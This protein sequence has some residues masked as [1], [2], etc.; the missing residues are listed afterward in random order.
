[1]KRRLVALTGALITAG[2]S[3]C[4]LL[5]PKKAKVQYLEDRGTLRIDEAHSVSYLRGGEHGSPRVIFVHGTPGEAKD[6]EAYVAEPVAGS[7]SVAIDRFGFGESIPKEA[8]TSLHEQALAIEPFLVKQGGRW[9][10]LVGHSYGGPVIA[11]AAA[12][13]PDRIGGIVIV[14]GALD[15]GLEKVSFMQ[16][17][18]EFSFMP[19]L[20]P[21]ALR[22]ANRE[23]IPLKG[24]LEE[25]A[26]L[27]PTIKVPIIIIH[28][29]KDPL[30][31]FSNVAYMQ[32][33]FAPEVVRDTIVLEGQNHFLPWNSEAVIRG[34]IGNLLQ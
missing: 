30:V 21:G 2:L 23:L 34:A 20:L 14:A 16:R 24:E 5:P 18:G 19:G 33:H 1:M 15:P 8:V 4:S 29:T 10:I 13:W 27:L 3:A 26:P 32:G 7:E 9:P 28:G 31:P 25:L 12:E 22:N 6:W 11:R 17:V